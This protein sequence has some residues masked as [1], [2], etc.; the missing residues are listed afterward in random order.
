MRGVALLLVV[1]LG[2]GP[3][4]AIA[5]ALPPTRAAFPATQPAELL[6]GDAVPEDGYFYPADLDAERTKAIAVLKAERRAGYER[7][8]EEVGASLALANRRLTRWARAA[9]AFAALAFGTGVAVGA[10]AAGGK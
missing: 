8:R 1:A 10:T 2:C 6:A 5:P 3:V 7:G 9:A 4:P